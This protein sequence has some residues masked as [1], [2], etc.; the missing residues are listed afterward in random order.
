[1]KY[2][3]TSV[4]V[5]LLTVETTSE[6]AIAWSNAQPTG[7]L[8]S[9]Y[10]LLTEL[11]SSLSRKVRMHRLA[12]M[13]RDGIMMHF[14]TNI[15]PSLRLVEIGMDHFQRAAEIAD[16]H[17]LGIRAGDAL[18]LAVAQEH[19]YPVCTFDQKLAS[20]AAHLGYAVELIA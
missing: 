4:L 1:M 2:L 7:S 13:E 19:G 12:P 9:S 18:H 17:E 6:R 10:W 8:M 20:G 16:I 15:L 3:E 11:S 14:R 5:S